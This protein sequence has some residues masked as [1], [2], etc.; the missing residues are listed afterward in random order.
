MCTATCVPAS[1]SLPRP[2]IW[3]VTNGA[4]A[5]PASAASRRF[6][7]RR[8]TKQLPATAPHNVTTTTITMAAAGPPL[9]DPPVSS[10]SPVPGND[11]V[12]LLPPTFPVPTSLPVDDGTTDAVVS[13]LLGLG[14]MAVTAALAR[15][16]AAM[17]SC[18]RVLAL[19]RRLGMATEDKTV[20]DVISAVDKLPGGD[21]P[22][23]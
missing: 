9:S 17:L 20:I 7:R 13:A 11:P 12:V 15:V 5:L 10:P 21:T 8:S 14:M 2:Y 4:C 6:F 1:A 19:L 22:G 16:I 23:V 18:A 3:F